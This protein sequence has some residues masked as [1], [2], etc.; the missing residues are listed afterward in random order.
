MTL[1]WL[2]D[3][4][5]DFV[6]SL[7]NT[8]RCIRLGKLSG[9]YDVVFGLVFIFGWCVLF[10]QFADQA[11]TFCSCFGGLVGNSIIF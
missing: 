3:F 11:V 6:G 5:F 2:F 4:D 1:V 7:L 9:N 10:L 8:L